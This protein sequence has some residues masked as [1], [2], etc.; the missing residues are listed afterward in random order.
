[1]QVKRYIP[2]AHHP[3]HPYVQSIFAARGCYAEEHILPMGVVDIL[4]NLGD[5]ISAEEAPRLARPYAWRTVLVAG[6]QTTTVMSRPLG[7]M[8]IVGVNLKA[9]ACR[10]VIPLPLG[11]LTDL[12]M[13]GALLFPGVRQLWEQLGEARSFDHQRRLLSGWL[14]SLIEPPDR[15]ALIQHACH[16]L[17]AHPDGQRIDE[18]MQA[19][20]VSPRHLRR[21]F[22]QH[23]GIG[24]A[25]YLRLSRFTK[26]LHLMDSP[27]TL[28]E[29]AHAAH[30][31]DQAHFCRDFRA[32]AGRAPSQYRD[33]FAPAPGH[34]FYS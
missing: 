18:I 5:P 26:A 33:E 2:P 32:M 21:L 1:M 27:R 6:L 23:V 13:D 15:A 7:R 30:Y 28:T 34:V 10:A 25:Q 22:R 14:L 20:A 24:P 19:S 4:F 8:S 9:A 17:G 3:L 12:C 11:E 31:Y 29:I 16:L